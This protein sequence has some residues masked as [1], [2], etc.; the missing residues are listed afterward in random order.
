MRT[1][2]PADRAGSVF[3][4]TYVSTPNDHSELCSPIAE[5]DYRE[6]RLSQKFTPRQRVAERRAADVP[7]CIVFATLGDPNSMRCDW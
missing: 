5:H 7:T 6:S 2:R 1:S 3:D 4:P